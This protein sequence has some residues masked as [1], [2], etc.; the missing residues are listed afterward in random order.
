MFEWVDS[1]TWVEQ[2]GL[3]VFA[4]VAWGLAY[5]LLTSETK[6][7]P[8]PTVV[9]YQPMDFDRLDLA[10]SELEGLRGELQRLA[11]SPV[12]LGHREAERGGALDEG[13][14][15]VADLAGRGRTE[16]GAPSPRFEGGE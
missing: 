7:P 16:Q 9:P 8:M 10:V 5:F 4:A 15:V 12:A 6:D 14:K 2:G 11:E 1:L 13:S 3:W